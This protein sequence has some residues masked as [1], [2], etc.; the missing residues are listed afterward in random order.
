[1]KISPDCSVFFSP[2]AK[3][4]FCLPNVLIFSLVAES[5]GEHFRLYSSSRARA[6][7]PLYNIYGKWGARVG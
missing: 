1:M 4:L 5:V 7:V 3:S 6:R 2:I